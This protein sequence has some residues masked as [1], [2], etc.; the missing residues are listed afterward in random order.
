MNEGGLPLKLV[1]L[2]GLG[3]WC[4]ANGFEI[5]EVGSDEV[6]LTDA[7]TGS[8][9]SLFRVE[10]WLQAKGLVIDEVEPT[11]A[12]CETLVRLH[13]RLI[14]CRFALDQQHGL[15]IV[16][17]FGRASQ[18]IEG[19]GETLMQM[20]SI[21][22]QTAPMLDKVIEKGAAADEQTIDRAFGV[23]GSLRIH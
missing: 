15:V 4:T 20:Q 19:I 7:E 2:E 9:W 22:D 14:G 5:E 18:T 12:L 1:T 16:A 17:D 10:D 23:M 3:E 8:A 11:H 13:D 21:I 6:L